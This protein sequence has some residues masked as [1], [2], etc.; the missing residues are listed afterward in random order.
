LRL[1]NPRRIAALCL[2]LTAASLGGCISLL[3]KEKPVQLYRFEAKPG[4]ASAAAAPPAAG[5]F[6]VR[7]TPVSFERAAAGDRILTIEGD[8]AAF[9]SSARWVTAAPVLFEAALGRAFQGHAGPAHLRDP[10]E[11]GPSDYMLKLDVRTFEVRYD[12][13]RGEAPTVDVEIYAALA[14]RRSTGPDATHIFQAQA[15]AASNSVHAITEAF[16][17]ALGKTLGELTAWVDAK[18]A[19]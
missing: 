14:A 1:T 17:Q 12:R 5:G 7:R 19:G 11:P 15:P 16:D 9:I 3:P 13:G 2:A 6:T 4:A 8:Q 18:G 10:G